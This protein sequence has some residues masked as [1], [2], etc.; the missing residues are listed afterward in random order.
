MADTKEIVKKLI[1]GST[2]IPGDK[3]KKILGEKSIDTDPKIK[4][5]LGKTTE[6]KD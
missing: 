4:K 2:T 5:I 3:I 6:S 1:G